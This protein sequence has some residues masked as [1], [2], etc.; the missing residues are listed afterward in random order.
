MSGVFEL[1]GSLS[2]APACTH[3]HTFCVTAAASSLPRKIRSKLGLSII[4]YAAPSTLALA[5]RL[6]NLELK[7]DLPLIALEQ[8]YLLLLRYC[9]A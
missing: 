7:L 6:A 5:S 2:S 3:A 9:N 4:L 1:R 8:Y